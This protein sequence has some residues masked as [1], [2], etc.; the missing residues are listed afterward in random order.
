MF[1]EFQERMI[2]VEEWKSFVQKR[3]DCVGNILSR[4]IFHKYTRVPW[5]PRRSLGKEHNRSNAGE[6]GYTAI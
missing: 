1:L 3:G 5:G 6:E 4:E 2:M